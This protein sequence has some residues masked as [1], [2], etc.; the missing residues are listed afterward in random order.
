MKE[1]SL[2]YDQQ[3]EGLDISRPLINPDCIYNH[4][5]Y[6]VIFPSEEILLRIFQ[7][8]EQNGVSARRYFY[9][10]LNKLHF[11]ESPAMHNAESI[12]KRV[13]C[14]PLYFDLDEKDITYISSIIKKCM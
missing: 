1:L 13:L 7:H 12:S 14:L 6:A 11:V 4:A 8:L 10:A 5:Y 2:I 9:P 3:L